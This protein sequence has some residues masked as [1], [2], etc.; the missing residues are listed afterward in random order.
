[1]RLFS[2]S[3]TFLRC[4]QLV[5]YWT[6]IIPY[7]S[8]VFLKRTQISVCYSLAH[9]SNAVVM[10]ALILLTWRKWWTPNNARKRQMGFNSAF[11]GL[12]V[13]Q[14][15]PYWINEIPSTNEEA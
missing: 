12:N 15:Y 3:Y 1:L 11:K 7:M 4:I 9:S 2:H 10:L 6:H 8:P 14:Y 5:S 13:P